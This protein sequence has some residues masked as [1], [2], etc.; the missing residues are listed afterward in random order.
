MG[1]FLIIGCS[2]FIGCPIKMVIRVSAG[3]LSAIAGV[4]GLVAGVWIGLKFLDNGFRLGEP[5]EAPLANG[6]IIPLVYSIS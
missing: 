2:V 4:T 6:L 5:S 1:A 3:D